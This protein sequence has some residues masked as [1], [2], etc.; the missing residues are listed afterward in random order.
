MVNSNS[1]TP[2][3]PSNDPVRMPQ[4]ILPEEVIHQLQAQRKIIDD[5]TE[6]SRLDI[7]LTPGARQRSR[8]IQEAKSKTIIAVNRYMDNM[9]ALLDSYVSIQRTDLE[10]RM[11]MYIN[12]ALA[13]HREILV[14]IIEGSWFSVV[15]RIGPGLERIDKMAKIDDQLK[16]ELKEEYLADTRK[17]AEKIRTDCHDILDTVVLQLQ[18]ILGVPR[19]V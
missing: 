1:L 3:D 18:N 12:G 6:P 19:R 17:H 15:E 11:K 9:I 5:E 8:L 7:W 10:L 14:G 13:Q 4:T 16:G 2:S